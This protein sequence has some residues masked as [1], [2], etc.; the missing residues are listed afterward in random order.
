[1]KPPRI[2]PMQPRPAGTGALWDY[3]AALGQRQDDH[4]ARKLS[5]TNG[6]PARR[7]AE[8]AEAEQRWD[9]EGGRPAPL[10]R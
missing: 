5:S 7:A 6:T 9:G 1:M 3:A 2:P 4:A 8:L 10:P